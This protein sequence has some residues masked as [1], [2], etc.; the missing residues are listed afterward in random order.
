MNMKENSLTHIHLMADG[1]LG[2]CVGKDK[3]DLV[4]IV[5]IGLKN[6]LPEKKDKFRLHR[7]LNTIFSEKLTE[8]EKI[9]ILKKEYEILPNQEFQKEMREMCNLGQGILERGIKQGTAQKNHTLA[10]MMIQ[11]KEPVEKIERYTGYTLQNIRQIAKEMNK[12]L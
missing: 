11:D 12:T 10:Q 9:D 4:N 7:L 3:L 6:E 1:K 8:A 2:K 5:M